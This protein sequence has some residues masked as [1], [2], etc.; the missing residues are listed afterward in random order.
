MHN[1]ELA[2]SYTFKKIKLDTHTHTYYIHFMLT[3]FSQMEMF[4]FTVA[5]RQH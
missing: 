2:K 4:I 3:F 5:Q 1:K